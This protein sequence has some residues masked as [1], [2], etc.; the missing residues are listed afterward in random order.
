MSTIRESILKAPDL[1]KEPVSAW[2]LDFF[3]REMSGAERDSFEAYLLDLKEQE[4]TAPRNIR[5]TLI[6]K[7]ACDAEGTRLFSDADAAE[8]GKKSA[9][10]LDMLWRKAI[11]INGLSDEAEKE[12]AKN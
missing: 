11:A 10:V 7:T 12:T 8:L 4:P 2:G 3:I 5:A 9:G 6:A 1:I